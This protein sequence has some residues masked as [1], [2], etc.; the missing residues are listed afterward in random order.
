MSR[1][2]QFQKETVADFMYKAY[3]LTFGVDIS[4]IKQIKSY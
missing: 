2:Y 4:P 3:L 1:M